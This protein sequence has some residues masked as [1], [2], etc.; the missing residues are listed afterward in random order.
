MPPSTR[1]EFLSDV[2]F[3]WSY[4]SAPLYEIRAVRRARPALFVSSALLFFR[5]EGG[6]DSEAEWGLFIMGKPQLLYIPGFVIL[7]RARMCLF[8][9]K[10]SLLGY[11]FNSE[12]FFSTVGRCKRLPSFPPGSSGVR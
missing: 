8:T 2:L 1:C 5:E 4:N 7:L 6:P 12:R 11:H 3:N 9:P 10:L